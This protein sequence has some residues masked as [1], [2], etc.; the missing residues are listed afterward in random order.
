MRRI[1]IIGAGGAG[2]STLAG[3]LGQKLGIPVYHLDSLFWKPNWTPLPRE[4]WKITVQKLL[5]KEEWILDGNFGSTLD[6]R[7]EAADTIIFLDYSSV[8]CLYGVVK[9]RIQYHGKTRPDMGKGCPEKLD[10]EFLKWVAGYKK[11]KSPEI[12]SKLSKLENKQ[13]LH[14]H[15][16]AEAYEFLKE[17]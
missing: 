14:F 7:I 9:R 2:K 3:T 11:N 16:P 15:T 6:M 17:L 1:L 13:V 5:K 8:R 12:I 4:Q 10:W